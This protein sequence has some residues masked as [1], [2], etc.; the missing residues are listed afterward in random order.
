MIDPRRFEDLL[1]LWSDAEASPAELEEFAQALR[2]DPERRR[3]LVRSVMVDV[4]LYGRYAAT[5]GAGA[6]R[7]KSRSRGWEAA[8]ALL[9]LA[10]SA[11][12][13]GRLFLMKKPE[14]SI[15]AP[16]PQVVP[17]PKIPPLPAPNPAAEKL[18]R[19][20]D[21]STLSLP[22]AVDLALEKWPGIPVKAELSEEEGKVI[23]TVV[24]ASERKSREVEID[25]ASGKVLEGQL[26][27]EDASAVAAALKVP[28]RTAV[29]KALAAVPGRPVEA[30]AE[31]EKGRLVVEVK[32]LHDGEVR[33][34]LVDGETGEV[35]K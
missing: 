22:Q 19:L 26:E 5:A 23:W 3:E 34:I 29:E 13:L 4:N 31:F 17:L 14:P 27:E 10:L 21:R 24:L 25:A 35:L 20:L 2:D 9:V 18:V 8:A 15:A 16:R 30:D 33:E 28:I 32:V 6:I 7:A 11:F 12:L 1:R